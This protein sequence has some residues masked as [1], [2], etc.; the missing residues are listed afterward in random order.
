MFNGYKW[1]ED[2]MPMPTN[3]PF[4]YNA[5]NNVY[6]DM[7][8]LQKAMIQYYGL[9]LEETGEMLC[10]SW[11]YQVVESQRVECASLSLMSQALRGKPLESQELDASEDKDVQG[12][13]HK[14][15]YYSV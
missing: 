5:Y 4:E 1:V 6:I 11:S 12:Q 7:E 3:K 2:I 9:T 10:L 8:E 13:M 14:K 15:D